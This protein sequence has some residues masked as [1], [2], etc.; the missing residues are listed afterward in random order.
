M[1]EESPQFPQANTIH[2]KANSVN[3]ILTTKRQ[4][5]HPKL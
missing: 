2:I 1:N 4:L 5:S 3:Q